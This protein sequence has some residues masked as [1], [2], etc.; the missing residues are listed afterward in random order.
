MFWLRK[1][2][3]QNT[4]YSRYRW[5]TKKIHNIQ[6]LIKHIPGI[7]QVS[8]NIHDV[9]HYSMY[10]QYKYSAYSIQLI[11]VKTEKAQKV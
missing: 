6:V 10:F 9:G 11:K 3:V 2:Y 7:T 5:Y 1:M 8:H 4:I